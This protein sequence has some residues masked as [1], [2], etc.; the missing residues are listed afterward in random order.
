MRQSRSVSTSRPAANWSRSITHEFRDPDKSD[1]S[2]SSL[3]T[4][5]PESW[6][7]A[8]EG[9]GHGRQRLNGA[10]DIVDLHRLIETEPRTPD[11]DRLSASRRDVPGDRRS[12][13]RRSALRLVWLYPRFVR[14]TNRIRNNDASRHRR[15]DRG[16]DAAHRCDVAWTA[17]DD[18]VGLRRSRS[19]GSRCSISRH[20]DAGHQALGCCQAP[21]LRP[22]ADPGPLLIASITRA[23]RRRCASHAPARIRLPWYALTADV[24]KRARVAGLGIIALA[25]L[26]GRPIVPTAAG[27]SRR[28]EFNTWDRAT[29]GLPFRRAR[30]VV[31]GDLIRVPADADDAAMEGARLAVERGLDE[32]HRRVYAMVGATDPGSYLRPA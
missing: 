7:L 29:L 21:A 24:P 17:S 23:A 4:R 6:A 10:I 30:P 20:E 26:S 19:I 16:R 31:V 15:G 11:P 8:S 2:A 5:A 12:R 22:Y 13:R 27:P 25:K 1:M 3:I 32:A 14:R 28:I 9:A 18:A